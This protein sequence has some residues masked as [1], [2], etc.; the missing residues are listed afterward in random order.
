MTNTKNTP[1]EALEARAE[2]LPDKVTMELR[3]G[4]VVRMLTPGGGGWGPPLLA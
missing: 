1:I 3:S 2:R 4:D